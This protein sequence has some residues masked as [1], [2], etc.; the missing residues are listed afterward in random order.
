MQVIRRHHGT[1]G[2]RFNWHGLLWLDDSS[3]NRR[4]FLRLL[5][6]FN[7]LLYNHATGLHQF[8]FTVV[9]SSVLCHSPPP[10]S[11]CFSYLTFALLRYPC[12]CFANGT[13]LG[14][15]RSFSLP[16]FPTVHSYL[17]CFAYHRSFQEFCALLHGCT[18]RLRRSF[19]E[20]ERRHWSC[21]GSFS[22]LQQEQWNLSS[23]WDL[24]HLTNVFQ[25][26]L[27]DRRCFSGTWKNWHG[28]KD[29]FI[30]QHLLVDPGVLLHGGM[31]LPFLLSLQLPG[32]EHLW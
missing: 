29:E 21:Q 32:P 19:T 23:M 25:C 24:S 10:S 3:P 17:R 26:P 18:F 27:P 31:S 11:C 20:K 28:W 13:G 15:F 2:C 22:G 12:I 14:S 5:H 16:R 1:R 7:L 30:S 9:L 6:L 4:C 8:P